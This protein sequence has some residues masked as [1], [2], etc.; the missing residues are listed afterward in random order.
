M[1]EAV[2]FSELQARLTAMVQGLSLSKVLT[3]Q[4]I[5]KHPNAVLQFL[6]TISRDELQDSQLIS[7][8]NLC[9]WADGHR[10]TRLI[11]S[12]IHM[13]QSSTRAAC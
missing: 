10:K 7:V 5:L 9:G 2:S 8:R 1:A 12:S 11:L 13:R 3:S 6:F 4:P